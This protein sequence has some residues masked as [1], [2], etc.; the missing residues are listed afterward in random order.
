MGDLSSSPTNMDHCIELF[1][2]CARACESVLMLAYKS[3]M[4]W[5]EYTVFKC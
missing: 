5:L 1:I 2:K 4:F 3:Q